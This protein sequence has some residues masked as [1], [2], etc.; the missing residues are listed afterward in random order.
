LINYGSEEM[1]SIAGQSTEEISH[2]LGH[3]P[4]QEVVHRNNLIVL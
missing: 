2:L 1:Q 3:C 4:Y